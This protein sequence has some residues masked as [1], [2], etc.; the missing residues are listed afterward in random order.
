[1]DLQLIR[2]HPEIFPNFYLL[3]MP[4]LDRGAILELREF[5]LISSL[6]LRWILVALDQSNHDVLDLFLG[7]RE[8]RIQLY[9]GLLGTRLRHYYR[10]RQ[11]NHDYQAFLR[12][13]A[14]GQDL[15][16]QAL[17]NYHEAVGNN[18]A[19]DQRVQPAGFTIS[20]G[21]PLRWTDVPVK[22]K[23]IVLVE[24]SFDL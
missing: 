15:I 22:K 19:A 23:G 3:P 16:V 14:A 6:R 11:F 4:H 2:N 18:T 12:A 10:T 8:R 7:W 24:N 13:H 20:S 9:P 17:L 5:S 1:A 21:A